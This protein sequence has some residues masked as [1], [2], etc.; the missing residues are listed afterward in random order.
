MGLVKKPRYAAPVWL[1]V[2][3]KLIDG[4]SEITVK[5]KDIMARA[6]D[7]HGAVTLSWADIEQRVTNF[8]KVTADLSALK[9]GAAQ[10]AV[11]LNDLDAA[12]AT[13]GPKLS[14]RGGGETA[15][16]L[17]KAIRQF[18]KEGPSG[19]YGIGSGPDAFSRWGF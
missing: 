1:L 2:D 7:F 14:G 11:R 9:A 4:D 3:G 19:T 12:L 13:I 5:A 16:A 10:G 8:P 6:D 15:S 17:L 18:I